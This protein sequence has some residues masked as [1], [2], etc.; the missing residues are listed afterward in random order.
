MTSYFLESFKGKNKLAIDEL[1]RQ[2]VFH[3]NASPI[4]NFSSMKLKD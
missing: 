4:N 2:L 3:Y 1:K